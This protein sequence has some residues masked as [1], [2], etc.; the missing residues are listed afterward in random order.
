MS[1]LNRMLISAVPTITGIEA[2]NNFQLDMQEQMGDEPDKNRFYLE[3]LA[4]TNIVN[5]NSIQVT[6]Q[7]LQMM[8]VQYS[9]G[10]PLT[11]NHMKGLR[12]DALGIGQ[13]VAGEVRNGSLFLRMYIAKNKT[14][15]FTMLGGSNELIDAIIDGYIKNGSTSII[16][17]KATCSVCKS[18]ID[19]RFGCETHPKGR[20]M[21]VTN[22]AGLQE[23]VIPYI[24]VHE[25]EAI[26]FSITMLSADKNSKVTM[27][28]LNM[29]LDNFLDLETY[30]SIF[31]NN[32]RPEKP[33]TE[34]QGGIDVTPEEKAALEAQ[35]KAE[36]TRADA[37]QSVIDSQL[38]QIN[39][40]KA[41]LEKLRK[42]ASENSVLIEDGRAARKEFVEAYI[43]EFNAS[44][45]DAAT[46]ELEQ[47][48]RELCVNF[49]LDKIKRDTESLRKVN[50]KRYP[51]GNVLGDG[52]E[53]D[54][55][56]S[57]I[58]E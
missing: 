18:E 39:S 57:D 34:P 19:G 36:R 41:E 12:D 26:E 11:I 17:I 24:I 14:Y 20:P 35:L 29:H 7:A 43:K 48:Q 16:P 10:L 6:E 9:Q 51:D 23:T 25:A 42:E 49:T 54:D 27:K 47:Q 56:D 37:N 55:S 5:R 4:M 1:N 46:P 50:K 44:E 21:L 53:D 52:E 28:N 22:D 8:G 3:Y 45:G 30:N 31:D 15:N 40:Q 13:T 58:I 38:M 2:F 32:P 33:N